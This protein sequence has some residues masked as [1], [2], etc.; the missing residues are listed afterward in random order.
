MLSSITAPAPS[1][2]IIES[3]SFKSVTLDKV[4][5]PIIRHLLAIFDW[6]NDLA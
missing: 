3:L 2:Y 1:A 6:I 4:S 5:L